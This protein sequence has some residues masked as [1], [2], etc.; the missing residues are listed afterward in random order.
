VSSQSTTVGLW[1]PLSVLS[2]KRRKLS[3]FPRSPQAEIPRIVA[4]TPTSRV[5]WFSQPAPP[6]GIRECLNVLP[7]L[8]AKFLGGIEG[9]WEMVLPL[10]KRDPVGLQASEID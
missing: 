8:P 9:R 7:S 10:A 5:C 2:R 4:S 1:R 3:A 6:S